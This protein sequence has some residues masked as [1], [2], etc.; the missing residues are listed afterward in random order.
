MAKRIFRKLLPDPRTVREHRALRFLGGW[1]HDPNLWHLNRRSIAGGFAVGLFMAFQPF[2]IQMLLAAAAAVALRVN[3]PI[4]VTLVWISNPLTMP[5]I[6]YFAY[7]VGVW[8]LGMPGG[9]RTAFTLSFSWFQR[10]FVE[11]WKPLMVGSL[12]LGSVSAV[13]GYIGMRLLWRCSVVYRWRRR[14][15]H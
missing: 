3:L 2:P 13:V 6:F 7:K 14:G 9:E 10:E 11:I 1:L 4:A 8:V 12:L 5:A 15:R